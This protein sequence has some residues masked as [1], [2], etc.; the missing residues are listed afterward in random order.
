MCGACPGGAGISRL[1]AYASLSGIR[2]EVASLLQQV[3][4]RRLGIKAFGDQWV[5]HTRTGSQRVVPGLEAVADAVVAGPVD[6]TGVA[7]VTGTSINGTA[8]QLITPGAAA[9]QR[10]AAAPLH[11]PGKALT[12]GEFTAALLVRAA[13]AQFPPPPHPSSPPSPSETH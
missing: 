13:N 7:A 11:A 8:P 10:I 4:G 6:W 1:S 5:L 3:A 12:A 2:A 9:L